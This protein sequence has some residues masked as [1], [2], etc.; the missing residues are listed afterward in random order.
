[1]LRLDELAYELRPDQA[2]LPEPSRAARPLSF[3][4]AVREAIDWETVTPLDEL[5]SDTITARVK[6]GLRWWRAA[7]A[8][9]VRS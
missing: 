5:P 3:K 2:D 7:Q 4:T 9:G 1:M 8:E 6:K